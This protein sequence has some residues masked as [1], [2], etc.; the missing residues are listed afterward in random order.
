[1]TDKYV[2]CC[3]E[4]HIV[5]L[6]SRLIGGAPGPN[7]SVVFHDPTELDTLIVAL[8]KLRDNWDHPV[9]H[10]HVQNP[11][12]L[13]FR[14]DPTLLEIMFVTSKWA[15]TEGERDIREQLV[16][17]AYRFLKMKS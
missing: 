9:G 1:M 6:D 17:D 4:H 3:D 12:H 16:K 5:R 15:H 10:I 8:K 7:G 14:Q 2:P 11:Q 13:D